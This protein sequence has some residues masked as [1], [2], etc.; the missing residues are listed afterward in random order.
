MTNFKLILKLIIAL[1]LFVS[2]LNSIPVDGKLDQDQRFNSSLNRSLSFEVIKKS[3]Y[4]ISFLNDSNVYDT[5]NSS[6]THLNL[7]EIEQR[8]QKFI[9]TPTQLNS[10]LNTK[11]LFDDSNNTIPKHTRQ[12]F[13]YK[14]FNTTN[15]PKSSLELTTNTILTVSN[16]TKIE[17]VTALI[18][19]HDNNSTL[20][21]PNLTIERMDSYLHLVP[22][23]FYFFMNESKMF[24]LDYIPDENMLEM[25]RKEMELVQNLV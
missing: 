12:T 2:I 1:S 19:G 25:D 9:F 14:Y 4:A 17:N 3:P 11:V 21:S 24:Y 18:S 23:M 8:M 6:S 13:L 7:T 16:E 15:S 5:S 10:S 20:L 22:Q